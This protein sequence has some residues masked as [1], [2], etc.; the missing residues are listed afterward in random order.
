MGRRKKL[1]LAIL[2]CAVTATAA[3]VA[4]NSA[5]NSMLRSRDQVSE[6][7]HNLER[8]Y[9]DLDRKIDELQNQK[10]QVGRYLTDCDKTLHDLDHAIAAQD[11]AF[12]GR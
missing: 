4:D 6:Q 8:A 12:R 10:Y 11:A 9:A 2:I 3:A 7:K 1:T 5:R